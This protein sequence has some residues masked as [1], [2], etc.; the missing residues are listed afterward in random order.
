[1]KRPKESAEAWT[2]HEDVIVEEIAKLGR[3][4]EGGGHR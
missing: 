2:T 4:G 3:H 1:M